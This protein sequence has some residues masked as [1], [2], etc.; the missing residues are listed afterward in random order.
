MHGDYIMCSAKYAAT[1]SCLTVGLGVELF[2]GDVAL[3]LSTVRTCWRAN[4]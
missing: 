1:V 4:A 2:L 3:V